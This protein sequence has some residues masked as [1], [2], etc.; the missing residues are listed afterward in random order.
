MPDWVESGFH[1][2]SRRLRGSVVLRLAEVAPAKRARRYDPERAREE[3]CSGLLGAVPAGAWVVA[4]D[5]RGRQWSSADLARYME[6]WAQS[7]SDVALLVGGADGLHPRCLEAAQQ[8]W[9]LSRLTLPHA[10]VRVLVA[11]QLYRAWSLLGNH[12]YHRA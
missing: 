10:L 2:Y 6:Q 4:L 1:D 7:A 9:A 8:C 11:E 12:P 5:E 3:E